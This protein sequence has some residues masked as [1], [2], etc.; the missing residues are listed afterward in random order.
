M[1]AT[2]PVSNLPNFLKETGY[3]N[4]EDPAA[5]NYADA[6]PDGLSFSERL[7]ASPEAQYA[8]V[9]IME[10]LAANKAEWMDIYTET[11]ALLDGFDPS[12]G[13]VFMVDLGG[14]HGLDTT[15]LL[16]RYPDLPAGSLVVQDLPEVLKL[17]KVP[18]KIVLCPYDFF[19]PQ[20]IQGPSLCRQ[21]SVH[22]SPR[23]R[24]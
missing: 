6:D 21:T 23:V 20:P 16:S 18:E 14:G 24:V 12:D 5:T 4:P 13:G 17:A 7:E 3:E 8:F 1:N 15:R 9:K 10:G 11:Q 2:A 19:T 22:G